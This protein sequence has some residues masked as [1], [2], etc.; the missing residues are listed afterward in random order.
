MPIGIRL[1]LCFAFLILWAAA[2]G[3]YASSQLRQSGIQIAQLDQT[4][5]EVISVLHVNNDVL[6]FSAVAQ[7]A[8]RIEDV[9]HLK[10]V[11]TPMRAQLLQDT[12]AAVDCLGK[13]R[14]GQPERAFTVSL[15]SYFQSTIPDEIE[16][17]TALAETSDWQAV[18][19]RIR[20]QV[21]EKN[22]ALG[23]LSA[24][25]D[26]NARADRQTALANIASARVKT[27]TTSIIGGILSVVFACLLG[28]RVTRSISGPLGRL[29]EGAAALAIGDFAYRIPNDGAEDEL[30]VVSDVIN[31]A[32]A[33]IQESRL[34]LE[35]RVAERTAD[36]E[37]ARLAAEAASQSKSE[38]LANMS[39]EIRTPMNG[40]LGMTE[41]ALD[42]SLSKE[43]REYLSTVKSSGESLLT[44]VNDILDFSRIEAGRLSITPIAC[45]LRESLGDTL[46]PLAIRAEQKGL[47]LQFIVSPEVPECVSLDLDRVR[48]IVINLVGNAIKFTATGGVEL[49]VAVSRSD[50]ID[51]TLVFSVRDTGIGISPDKL[52]AVFEA[53]TQADGSIT[54]LYGGT[55]LGLAICSGLARLLDGRIWVESTVGEG[56]C[57][58]FA[59]PCRVAES[60]VSGL[61]LPGS[62][63]G[64]IAPSDTQAP[65]RLLLA[66]DNPVNRALA[67]RL[68]EKAGHS[69]VCVGDGQEAVETLAKDASFDLILMDLQM[70]R[71]G[72]FEATQAIRSAENVS[73]GRHIPIIALTAHAMKGD[74]ERCI[75]A[76]MDDYLSKP[77]NK[78]VLYE[79]L[80]KWSCAPTVV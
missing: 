46:K 62:I 69:V 53:F 21:S 33:S 76:G 58:L 6:R 72:G 78:R 40:I 20:N 57:F 19:L 43:Q 24:R 74:E 9:A 66:E 30:A 25:I 8:A 12:Q 61:E 10:A 45:N 55:G 16:V 48:Q 31:N 36:L 1:S 64:A 26:S 34:T 4:D 5:R 11:L 29:E 2:A 67:S 23:D 35:Q 38:F 32:A 15:L 77:I 13:N 41:L 14:V 7:E 50:E 80:R 37:G 18:R 49:H 79:K 60:R 65:L 47:H 56:S 75:D 42:T 68:L 59:L 27:F 73:G 71:M 39:H 22:Q 70:P 51:G 17:L 28:F 3:I 44:L 54:R 52:T 63:T